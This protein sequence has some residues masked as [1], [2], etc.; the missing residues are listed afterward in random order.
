MG[1]ENLTR[2]PSWA[3]PKRL[4]GGGG[5]PP[6]D[7][8]EGLLDA[9]QGSGGGPGDASGT[10]WRRERRAAECLGGAAVAVMEPAQIRKGD[11]LPLIDRLYVAWHLRF[12]VQGLIR[13]RLVSI[14]KLLLPFEIE[15]EWR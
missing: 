2:G 15:A 4:K 13:P 7:P 12:V 3:L 5:T 11:D 1:A 6:Q 14:H 10:C 8:R 9:A